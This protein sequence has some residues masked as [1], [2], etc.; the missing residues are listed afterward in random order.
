MIEVDVWKIKEG[1]KRYDV[2][3]DE[4][5]GPDIW[6]PECGCDYLEAEFVSN[7]IHLHCTKCIWGKAWDL[8]ETEDPTLYLPPYCDECRSEKLYNAKTDQHRCVFC[9]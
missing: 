2:F 7:R 3:T 5:E 8:G 6:C 9:P 4:Y 1:W